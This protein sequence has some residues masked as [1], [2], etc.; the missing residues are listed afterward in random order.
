MLRFKL[1]QNY[2]LPDLPFS[3]FEIPLDQASLAG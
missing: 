1:S 2:T 3:E